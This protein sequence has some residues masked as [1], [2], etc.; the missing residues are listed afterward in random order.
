[1]LKVKITKKDVN[2]N[3]FNIM[4][5]VFYTV[6]INIIYA[7]W[8]YIAFQKLW[9]SILIIVLVCLIGYFVGW[10][11]TRSNVLAKESDNKITS[12]KNQ[13]H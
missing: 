4:L 3:M 8:A 1:M 12:K 13:V 2:D 9:I 7:Y 10:Y 5:T 11:W 6:I